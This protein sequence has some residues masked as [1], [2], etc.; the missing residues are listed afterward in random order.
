MQLAQACLMSIRNAAH[1]LCLSLVCISGD[2]YC[3]CA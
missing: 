3:M 2:V 1:A